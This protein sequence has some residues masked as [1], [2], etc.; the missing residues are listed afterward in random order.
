MIT[1]FDGGADSSSRPELFADAFVDQDVRIDGHADGQHDARDTGKGQDRLESSQDRHHVKYIENHRD[2]GHQSRALVV[3]NH[4]DDHQGAADDKRGN[5]LAD[6]VLAQRRS[7][8][9]LLDDLDRRRQRAG[10]QNDRQIPR[11]FDIEAAGNGC[12][13]AADPFLNYRR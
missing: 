9:S 10:A 13:T 4:K 8:G 2:H 1:R 11:F 5:P 7:D 12:P 6:R 3:G